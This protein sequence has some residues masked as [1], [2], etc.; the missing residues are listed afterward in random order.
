MYI[1]KH[2]NKILIRK[3][4]DHVKIESYKFIGIQEEI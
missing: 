4:F 3:K 1:S 2:K